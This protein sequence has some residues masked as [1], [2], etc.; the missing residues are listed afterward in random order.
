MCLY[1]TKT[2]W[3]TFYDQFGDRGK[4]WNK[5]KIY[6]PI[7]LWLPDRNIFIVEE[8]ME[9]CEYDINFSVATVQLQWLF[10]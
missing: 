5:N 10:F 3:N 9:M 8:Y 2:V 1:V 7:N 6:V 4:I